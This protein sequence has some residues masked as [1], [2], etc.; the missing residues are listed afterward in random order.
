[1]TTQFASVRV[2]AERVLHIYRVDRPG[3]VR[4]VPWLAPAITR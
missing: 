1:M 2:P 3:Q 4:G